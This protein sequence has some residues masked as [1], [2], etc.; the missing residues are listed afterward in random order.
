MLR[1]R[2]AIDRV[3]LP[4]ILKTRRFGYDGKGQWPIAGVDNLES[5]FSCLKGA[6]AIIERRVDFSLECSVIAARSSEGGFAAYDPP[7]NVHSEHILRRAIVPAPLTPDQSNEA[8]TIAAHIAEVLEYVGVLAV[9]FFVTREGALLVNEIAPRVHNSGHW[10]L[11]ACVVNQFEQHI[12]AIAGW[13]LGDPSR[14]SNAVMDNL[15]GAE[16]ADWQA[17]ARSSGAA[18]HLYGKTEIRS[19]RKM[20]HV[21]RL[22][23]LNE[24]PRS[25]DPG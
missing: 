23:P 4:A 21:T 22:W 8:K 1:A 19:G 12:R 24:M 13:P 15:I 5:A 20:G 25:G 3:G 14:H 9:E 10:T 17:L 18:L 2:D 7:E 6:P 11:E 16:A